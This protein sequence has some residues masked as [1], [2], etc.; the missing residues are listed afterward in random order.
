MVHL[1]S[2]SDWILSLSFAL[3][4]AT[5]VAI[6][7]V[8]HI[9]YFVIMIGQ[10]QEFIDTDTKCPCRAFGKSCALTWMTV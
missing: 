7:A 4:L 2:L 6:M 10:A 1:L 9:S 8:L 3:S 5:G